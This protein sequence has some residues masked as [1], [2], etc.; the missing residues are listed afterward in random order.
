MGRSSRTAGTAPRRKFSAA[1][2]APWMPLLNDQAQRKEQM[3][4]TT[5]II[6]LVAFVLLVMSATALAN[7]GAASW[8][9]A[10]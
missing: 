5:I 3:K 10:I 9:T 2:L 1:S 6:L 7:G 4:R 8:S